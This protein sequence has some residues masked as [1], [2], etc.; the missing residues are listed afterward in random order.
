MIYMDE[1]TC[2]GTY[3]IEEV[4]I[5][6]DVHRMIHSSETFGFLGYLTLLCCQHLLIDYTARMVGFMND[7][8]ERMWKEEVMPYFTVIDILSEGKP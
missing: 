4:S 8:L 7:E 6:T 1:Q 2:F 3:N 5:F